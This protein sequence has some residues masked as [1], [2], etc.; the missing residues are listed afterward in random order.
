MILGSIPLYCFLRSKVLSYQAASN[1]GIHSQ[2]VVV[3][4]MIMMVVVETVIVVV[5]CGVNER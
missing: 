3:V 4:M 2:I 1:G 5:G